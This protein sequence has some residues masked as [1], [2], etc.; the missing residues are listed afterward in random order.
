[1]KAKKATPKTENH[2]AGMHDMGG[3]HM[4][5]NSAMAGMMLRAKPRT[6]PKQKKG[7]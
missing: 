5:S 7:K 4:M 2:G 1:M 6:P 3:G